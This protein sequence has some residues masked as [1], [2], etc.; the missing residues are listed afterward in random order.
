MI[1]INDIDIKFYTQSNLHDEC[2]DM[3][4][5]DINLIDLT[6]LIIGPMEIGI[7]LDVSTTLRSAYKVLYVRFST[8]RKRDISIEFIKRVVLEELPKRFGLP[9]DENCI[10]I[11]QKCFS[12]W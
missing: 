10:L 9:V 2:K 8:Y 6:G 7:Y 11:G 12:Y 1:N 5:E 4:L 3:S